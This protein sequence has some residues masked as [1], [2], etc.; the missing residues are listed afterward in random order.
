[1][2]NHKDEETPAHRGEGP[3]PEP[4]RRQWREEF[5]TYRASQAANQQ[6]ASDAAPPLSLKDWLGSSRYTFEPL[7]AAKNEIRVLVLR[8]FEKFD[9]PIEASFF[10]CSLD[11]WLPHE[12]LSYV[13]GTNA[14]DTVIHLDG[15]PFEITSHL[16]LALQ[17]YRSLDGGE[18]HRVIWVDAI[19]INQDDSVEKAQQVQVM[20]QIY[21]RGRMTFAY[22][23]EPRPGG[24]SL[25]GLE[26]LDPRNRKSSS[27]T[28]FCWSDDEAVELWREQG[29][30]QVEAT[31]AM[32]DML[33]MPWFRRVWVVQ[34]KAVVVCKLP[35]CTATLA[36]V[37]RR[38][39][40]RRGA[41]GAQTTRSTAIIVRH[42]TI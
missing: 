34:E 21:E 41:G 9:D 8:D 24:P 2:D 16:Q 4:T 6:S 5:M 36:L 10:V 11:D 23:G 28:K 42:T 12:C 26:L 31:S 7:D 18:G 30:D 27:S 32:L 14:P 33:K 3:K 38:L 40:L 1:M 25:R 29:I 19:C 22:I 15:K 39:P 13:W 17:R 20:R 37:S 35:F